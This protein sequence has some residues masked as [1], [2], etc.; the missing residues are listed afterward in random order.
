MLCLRFGS[1][2]VTVAL[3]CIALF[4]LAVSGL[5]L[6]W[7]LFAW[8]TPEAVSEMAWPDPATSR[9]PVLRFSLIV[10]A[11]D[12]AEHITATLQG[13][14]DQRYPDFEILVSLCD[15]D[16]PTIR[17]V[18][19][20]AAQNPG[21]LGI[22]T[23]HYVKP[24]KAHQLNSALAVASGD[25]VGVFD[26][27][28][29]VAVD[30]LASVDALFH[31]SQ[32]DVVQG[33]VQLMNLGHGLRGWFQVHNVLEYFFWFTSRM[34]YQARA[35]FVPLGG[36]TVFVRRA[37]LTA[38]GG[39]P[40]SLTEDCALGVLLCSRFG[41]KV[42]SAYSPELVTREETPPSVFNRAEGSLFWQRDRWIRGF[43]QELRAGLWREM[44]TPR[45]RFLAGYILAT[46][47]LQALS[48][49]LF[50]LA[51]LTAFLVKVPVLLALLLFA[52]LITIGM[53]AITQIL[54]LAEFSRT[55]GQKASPWH[56]ASLLL[57]APAY[58][59]VLMSAALMAAYKT[60]RGDVTWYKTG[61]A[62]QHRP[63]AVTTEGVR[64][65]EALA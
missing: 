59:F 17:A 44:P 4:N 58:Q 22:V 48:F 25:V 55:Y 18:E 15:D 29:D 43:I 45:Q 24:M 56:Y 54:G 49:V 51:L 2:A 3:A 35:G 53:T 6:R 16:E 14:L 8:R 10:A 41:A 37:L 20:L 46:P 12:E 23:G 11:R 31:E 26:A 9:A 13:L 39:W 42:V 47:L 40:A 50:P 27:E 36:N 52:P 21:R 57:L 32:A 38:A 34:G 1:S 64:T 19:A 65:A 63:S 30:L 28:D 60:S 7:R 62:G 5:E 61:R 33:G